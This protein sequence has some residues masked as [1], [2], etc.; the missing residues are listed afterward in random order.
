MNLASALYLWWVGAS[1]LHAS[2]AKILGVSGVA[3]YVERLNFDAEE[4]RMERTLKM[5]GSSNLYALLC[6]RGLGIEVL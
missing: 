3:D 6:A 2:S 5:D 4:L 1:R